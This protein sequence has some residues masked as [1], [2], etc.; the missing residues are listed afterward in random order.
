MLSKYF[1]LWY[2][3]QLGLGFLL[4]NLKNLPQSDNSI[5]FSHSYSSIVPSHIH[6][7][8]SCIYFTF[9]GK[10]CPI[11]SFGALTI[12]KCSKLFLRI[13]IDLAIRFNKLLTSIFWNDLSWKR[14]PLNLLQWLEKVRPLLDFQQFF[15]PLQ[16]LNECNEW[17]VIAHLK[18]PD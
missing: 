18:D 16:D 2:W 1:G 6:G 3:Y 5:F 17:G 13:E 14:P 10:L 7:K 4:R 9:R 12:I 8:F 15:L 11:M